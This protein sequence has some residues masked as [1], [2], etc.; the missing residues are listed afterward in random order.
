M[1]VLYVDLEHARV[2]EDDAL[3]PAHRA[4]LE[5]ARALLAEAAGE[6][7]HLAHDVAGETRRSVGTEDV[8]AFAF[9]VLAE[10]MV[11]EQPDLAR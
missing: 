9:A 7:R 2:R 6:P 5:A 11:A 1:T 8:G 4:R 10:R 3:G